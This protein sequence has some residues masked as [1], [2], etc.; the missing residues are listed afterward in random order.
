MTLDTLASLV[1][2]ELACASMKQSLYS[3]PVLRRLADYHPDSPKD[4]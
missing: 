4:Q 1:W 3:P 2:T